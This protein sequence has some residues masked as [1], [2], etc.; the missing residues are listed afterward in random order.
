MT[1]IEE[2]PKCF[3]LKKCP[4]TGPALRMHMVA[5]HMDGP[6]KTCGVCPHNTAGSAVDEIPDENVKDVFADAK[7]F[8][9]IDPYGPML[10]VE[11]LSAMRKEVNKTR[12]QIIDIMKGGKMP[13]LPPLARYN[14]ANEKTEGA[15]YTAGSVKPSHLIANPEVDKI[16]LPLIEKAVAL[17][18]SETTDMKYE[19][20]TANGFDT[21]CDPERFAKEV[22]YFRTN[23]LYCGVSSDVERKNAFARVEMNG[24]SILLTRDADKNFHAFENVCRHRGMEVVTKERPRGNAQVHVCPYHSWAYGSNGDL[25]NVPF[26]KGF[27]NND[28][29]DLKNRN[30]IPLPCA[31]VAG[32]LWVVSHPDYNAKNYEE[33]VKDILNEQLQKEFD[34]FNVG[35]NYAVVTQEMRLSCNW[36]L[37]IDTFGEAYHFKSLHPLLQKIFMRN[38]MLFREFNDTNGNEKN[39]CMVLLQSTVQLMADGDIPKSKWL[40]PSGVSHALP[41]Y[42][43]NPNTSFIVNPRGITVTQ[44][45]PTDKPGECIVRMTQYSDSNPAGFDKEQRKGIAAGFGNFLDIVATEDFEILAK[46]HRSFQESPHAE[47]VFGRNEPALIYRH[48]MFLNMLK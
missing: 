35:K 42:M 31:E 41:T 34:A 48:K 29:V 24:K 43:L 1:D 39:S 25:L 11:Q 21:Y 47:T 16:M 3:Y 30:L 14:F 15:D 13:D 12:N 19:P 44:A 20:V 40:T 9:I 33:L 45:F 4:T 7:S 46:M 2:V 10:E 5:S 28:K 8:P 26:S 22:E 27:E 17:V 37:P 38:R 36:K 18:K 6:R 23:F 32:T